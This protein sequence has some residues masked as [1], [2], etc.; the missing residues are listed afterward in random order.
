MS[1]TLGRGVR[2]RLEMQGF[3]CGAVGDVDEEVEPWLRTTPALSTAMI[4]AGTL[5]ASPAV[6]WLFAAI[7]A[8]AASRRVHPFDRIANAVREARTPGEGPLP[9]NPAPRRF[10]MVVASVWAVATGVLFAA[11]LPV[12]GY[13]SGGGLTLAGLA[14]ASTHF[15]LGSWMYRRLEPWLP[16]R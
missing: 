12:A 11:G 16:G 3:A 9:E 15:C 6:L 2:R 14:V 10:A 1:V 7:S 4:L 13:L 8:F 5:A